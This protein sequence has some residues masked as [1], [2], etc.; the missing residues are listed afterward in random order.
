M[1]P[2]PRHLQA[3][4][5]SHEV[6]R[7]SRSAPRIADVLKERQTFSFEFM[8]PKTDK[9]RQGLWRAIRQLEP[10]HP[11]FVSVTYGAGGSTRDRTVEETGKIAEDTSLDPVAHL[12]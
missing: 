7:I 5:A 11:T 1:P 6:R 10:L 3:S 2:R 9:A 8:P 12:T 4:L